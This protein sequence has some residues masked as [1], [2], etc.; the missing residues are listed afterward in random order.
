MKASEVLEIRLHPEWF[1]WI[2]TFVDRHILQ[3]RND[4]SFPSRWKSGSSEAAEETGTISYSPQNRDC[5]KIEKCNVAA[6]FPD[7][8]GTI[9]FNKR[10]PKFAATKEKYDFHTATIVRGRSGHRF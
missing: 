8:V 10:K 6:T 4:G 3:Q 5:V 2:K 7:K 1:S 9:L